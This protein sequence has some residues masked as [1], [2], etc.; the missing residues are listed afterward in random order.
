VGLTP[1]GQNPFTKVDKQ[2]VIGTLKATGSRDA[3]VLHAQK[4][5]ML[6]PQN[7]LKILSYILIGGGALLSI[8]VI[9][10]IAGIPLALFGVWMY[11]FSS[12]NIAAIEEGFSEYVASPASAGAEPNSKA[13]AAGT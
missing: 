5:K 11:R 7:N 12:K 8:T 4:A 3:D 2:T 10:A 13:M 6:A 9:L 1:E